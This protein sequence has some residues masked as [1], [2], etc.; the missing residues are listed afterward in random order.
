[1]SRLVLAALLAAAV[2]DVRGVLAVAIALTHL[3]TTMCANAVP[4]LALVVAA[5]AGVVAVLAVLIIRQLA[6]GVLPV[7]R[8]AS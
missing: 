7:S 3:A 6:P 1:M 8:W 2:R 4:I 5:E